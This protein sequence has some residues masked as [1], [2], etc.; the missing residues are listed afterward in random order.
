MNATPPL[1]TLTEPHQ[2]HWVSRTAFPVLVAIF[3]LNQAALGTALYLGSRWLAVP[4][5]LIASHLMHGLLIGLHE[6][7]HGLL[8]KS[9]RWN[10][11][12]GIIIAALSFMS[13]SLYRAAHPSHHAHLGTEP[14]PEPR[15]LV[16]PS[17]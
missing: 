16:N 9:R 7:A 13:F 11:V 14:D 5:M 15:T 12:D 8:R 10:E 3:F 6:A 4:L 17:T 1:E 2:P